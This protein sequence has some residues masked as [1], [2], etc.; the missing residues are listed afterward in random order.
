MCKVEKIS[1]L[2][3]GV[4]AVVF[5]LIQS[6]LL[7]QSS[8]ELSRL[9]FTL[10][11]DHYFFDTLRVEK[12]LKFAGNEKVLSSVLKWATI[13][14]VEPELVLSIIRHESNFKVSAVN[15]R[16]KNGSKDYGLMQLNSDVYGHDKELF[17]IDKNIELGVKNIAWCIE[18]SEGNLVKALVYYNAGIQR[19]KQYRVGEMTFDYIWKVLKTYEELKK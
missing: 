11:Q 13:M 6:V 19:S 4:L 12:L 2:V 14:K 7:V 9:K 1:V 18:K 10:E 3:A 16:N 5:V 17:D 8:N 15:S